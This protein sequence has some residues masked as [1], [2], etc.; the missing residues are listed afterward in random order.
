MNNADKYGSSV[1]DIPLKSRTLK[2]GMVLTDDNSDEW[3][4]ELLVEMYDR[5]LNGEKFEVHSRPPEE[6]LKEIE[7]EKLQKELE[8]QRLQDDA[9]ISISITELPAYFANDW[10][11]VVL[12]A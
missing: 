8:E 12:N 11:E 2:N 10:M 3:V 6:V 4:D 1:N 7:F 5:F 9:P